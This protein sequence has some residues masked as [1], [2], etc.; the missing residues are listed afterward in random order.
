MFGGDGRVA[1]RTEAGVDP[2][3]VGGLVARVG[4]AIDD[5]ARPLHPRAR[6]FPENE[7][8]L[9]AGEPGE[10]VERPRVPEGDRRRSHGW[11]LR[12]A[13]WRGPS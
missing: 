7:R 3:D 11:A 10:V 8:R 13:R 6:R 4:E 2:V 5:V 12:A 9:A 1:Q